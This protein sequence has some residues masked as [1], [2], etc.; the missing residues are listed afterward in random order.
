MV[1]MRNNILVSDKTACCTTRMIS[2][3][4]SRIR[5]SPTRHVFEILLFLKLNK[6]RFRDN[7][8][9]V[10]SHIGGVGDACKSVTS[11]I[12]LLSGKN[13]FNHEKKFVSK[14]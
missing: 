5:I 10:G 14:L 3:R 4:W 9:K 7:K 11:P 6:L 2:V 1:T 8:I 12:I 13:H